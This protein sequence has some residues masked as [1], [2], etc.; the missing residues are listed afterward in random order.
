MENLQELFETGLKFHGHKCPAMPM[1]LRAGLAAMK[2]LGVERAQDKEL[3]LKSQTGKGHA[4]GCFLDGLMTATGCT[5]GKSNIEK[6]YYNKMAFT[7]IDTETGRSVR[8]SLKPGFFEKA[9]GSPFVQ[10]RKAGVPPQDIEPE[11]TNPLVERILNLPESEFLDIGE[12]KNVEVQE[13]K[14]IF[15]AIPCEKCGELTFVNK[16]RIRPDEK[17]VCIPCSGYMG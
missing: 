1:G 10:K 17:M 12:I 13:G 4:A 14:G 5:Y 9:L 15:E 3:V 7:L 6:L 2:T 8:V 11:L 16:L